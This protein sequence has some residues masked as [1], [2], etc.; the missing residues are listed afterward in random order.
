MHMIVHAVLVAFW[1]LE[2]Y[3]WTHVYPSVLKADR[4]SS[5]SERI[6]LHHHSTAIA[7]ANR[8]DRHVAEFGGHT[9]RYCIAY[10]RG[11][12]SHISHR[13]LFRAEITIT[14]CAY[15]YYGA[16]IIMYR[17]KLFSLNF[18]IRKFF[19]TKNFFTKIY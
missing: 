3:G 9:P 18:F 15:Y 16:C 17:V 7:S 14:Q 6:A 11:N 13:P 8:E 4:R 1:I 19:Y 5:R 12:L 10:R 2:G